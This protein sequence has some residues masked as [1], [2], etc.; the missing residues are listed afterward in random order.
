[1]ALLADRT[2]EAVA[3]V[4]ALDR[5]RLAA[6]LPVRTRADLANSVAWIDL[7]AGDERH[8]EDAE[9]MAELAVAASDGAPSAALEDTLGWIDLRRGR[10]RSAHRR[11]ARAYVVPEARPHRWM[12]ARGLA[13]SAR[14]LGDEALA[15]AWSAVG[16]AAMASPAPP[17]SP[18]PAVVVAVDAMEAAGWAR[19]DLDHAAVAGGVSDWVE[20]RRRAE[21]RRFAGARWGTW[22]VVAGLTAA[23]AAGLLLWTDEWYQHPGRLYVAL[24][25]AGVSLVSAV[26]GTSTFVFGAFDMA[27]ADDFG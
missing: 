23:P 10:Y 26:V 6:L 16:T 12:I 3:M 8:L 1:M 24:A 18:A 7:L 9:A 13:L 11:F 20:A 21:G 22:L 2:T 15:S 14:G 27:G 5:A 17:P 25:F 19:T 4:D